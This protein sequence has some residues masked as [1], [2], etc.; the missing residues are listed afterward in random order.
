MQAM[1]PGD[2]D[3][4]VGTD[5]GMNKELVE[6]WKDMEER[7]NELAKLSN[8]KNYDKN[9]K[10]DDVLANLDAIRNPHKR[11]SPTWRKIKEGFNNTLTVIAKVG[12]MVADA[13][14]QVSLSWPQN[15]YR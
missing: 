11:K 15:A 14:S 6:A 5:V 3:V 10:P 12:G 13:A 2:G 7:M 1:V 8:G 4:P 9:L